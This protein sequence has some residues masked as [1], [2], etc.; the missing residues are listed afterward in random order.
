MY[1]VAQE[2]IPILEGQPTYIFLFFLIRYLFDFII[3]RILDDN[4]QSLPM[5]AHFQDYD[6]VLN[7]FPAVWKSKTLYNCGIDG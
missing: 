6:P 7:I 5:K 2:F 1:S 4:L 3:K